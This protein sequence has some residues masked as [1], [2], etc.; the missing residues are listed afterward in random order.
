M[1]STSSSASVLAAVSTWSSA[2]VP[3]M[4][5][6]PVGS[7]LTLATVPV[8][9]LVELSAVPWPSVY[10]AVTVIALPTSDWP[11]VVVEPVSPLLHV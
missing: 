6:D 10:D 2:A 11:S 4:V 8:A 7:S 9:A 3:L 5:T 1:P